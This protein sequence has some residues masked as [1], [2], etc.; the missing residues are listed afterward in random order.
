[1]YHGNR[2]PEFASFDAVTQGL[3]AEGRRRFC[4]I[5][6]Q[7]LDDINLRA[8][9]FKDRHFEMETLTHAVTWICDMLRGADKDSLAFVLKIEKWRGVI[10]ESAA[11]KI[12]HELRFNLPPVVSVPAAPVPATTK[13][14]RAKA[15]GLLGKIL[16][17]RS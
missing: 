8:P 10:A 5:L 11:A 15:K 7:Y 3:D 16:K 4:V 14:L 12:E 17:P 2:K 1:M 9:D 6:L 13:T